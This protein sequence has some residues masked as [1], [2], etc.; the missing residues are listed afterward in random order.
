MNSLKK[1]GI[2]IFDNPWEAE[3]YARK[4]QADIWEVERFIDIDTGNDKYML[5][6]YYFKTMGEV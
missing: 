5:K 6:T 4:K 2:S 3:E 1:M